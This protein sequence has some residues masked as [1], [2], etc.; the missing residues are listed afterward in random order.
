MLRKGIR[1]RAESCAYV[2]GLYVK[3]EQRLLQEAL[4]ALRLEG[5]RRRGGGEDDGSRCDNETSRKRRATSKP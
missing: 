2:A 1:A 3:G 5:D 4:E